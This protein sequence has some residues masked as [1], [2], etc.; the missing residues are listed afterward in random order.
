MI[1]I[2]YQDAHVIVCV[3]PTGISSQEAGE[4]SLP[5]RL[6]EQLGLRDL[7]VIHRLDRE[8][9]GVMVF[10]ASQSAAAALTREVQERT[11]EKRYLAVLNGSV[12]PQGVLEDLLFH[13][14]QRNK[15]Y[16]M[17]RSRK[18]VK[19]AKLEYRLV[20]EKDGVSLVDIL[21][22]TGRTHQI[23][24]QFSSRK[25]PLVGD[26]RYGGPSCEQIGLWSWSLKFRHPENGT[27]MHYTR[28]PSEESLP[29][30]QFSVQP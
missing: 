20:E 29:W 7:Y 4:D 9:G 17:Q 15:T 16:V 13:D 30:A 8:V 23:R 27:E 26:R 24:V 5:A 2:L 10:A 21:L 3:K 28:L 25:L 18:G 19:E 1:P 14:R 22:H 6:K 12:P 11:M